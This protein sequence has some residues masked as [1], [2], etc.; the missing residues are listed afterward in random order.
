MFPAE[1]RGFM[2]ARQ[3]I[4][5]A[6]LHALL[7]AA[8]LTLLLVPA[9]G[10]MSPEA[11]RLLAVTLLMAGL[12]VLQQIPLVATAFLPLV[13]FPLLGILPAEQVSRLYMNDQVLLYLGGFILALGI[14]RWGLHRRLALTIMHT[15]GTSP[16]RLMLG[17]MLATGGLSMWISNTAA[18]LLMLPIAL[19]LL[20][21]LDDEQDDPQPEQD[22]RQPLNRTVTPVSGRIAVPLL[23]SIPYSASLGGM[24]TLVGTPTNAQAV[25]VLREMAPGTPAISMSQWLFGC[26]PICLAYLVCAYLFLSWSLPKQMDGANATRSSQLRQRI[27]DRLAALGR[28]SQAEWRMAFLFGITALLWTFRTPMGSP[29]SFQ[30]PGWGQFTAVWIEWLGRSTTAA[31]SATYANDST[32]VIGTVFVMFL[33]PS[34]ERDENGRGLP[35]MDWPTARRLPWEVMFLVGSGFALAGG[36]QATGLAE[37]IGAGLNEVLVGQSVWLMVAIVCLTM[38]FL[39]EFTSN[40]ATIS[41]VAPIL[42]SLA[43]GVGVDPRL[44]VVPATLATSCAFMLPVA[45]PPNAIV[46]A[47]GKLRIADLCRY[48]FWLNLLGVPL[49]TAGTF[50]FI[51]PA[52]GLP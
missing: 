8:S 4:L 2:P 24:S 27:A 26:G 40:I 29:G 41:A 31:I 39:T 11:L 21:T 37:W 28:M 19:A 35:L 3:V 14:E 7:V 20:M 25:A 36:F 47:S 12:W 38:T 44:L 34:G 46:F 43:V 48:G 51:R 15:V 50:L 9:P 22:Q 42:V 5:F 52:L 33:L 32:V 6:V 13:L 18:T 30:I 1:T 16:R 10:G 23:I 17:F 49:I 45:T